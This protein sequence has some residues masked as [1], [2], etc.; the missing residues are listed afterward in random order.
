MLDRGLQ[1]VQIRYR[2]LEPA[3]RLAQPGV[4]LLEAFD[5]GVLMR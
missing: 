3:K 2:F 1:P 5:V 4:E